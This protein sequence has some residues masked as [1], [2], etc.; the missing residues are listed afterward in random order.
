MLNND[1]VLCGAK[2]LLPFRRF[3]ARGKEVKLLAC[4]REQLFFILATNSVVI[5]PVNK[6]SVQILQLALSERVPFDLKGNILFPC[7]KT[8]PSFSNFSVDVFLFRGLG[9]FNQAEISEG[10]VWQST[11]EEIVERRAGE[12]Q[13]E[14]LLVF[15]CVIV[16]PSKLDVFVDN[17]LA[18]FLVIAEK[19]NSVSIGLIPWQQC[20]CSLFTCR[21]RFSRA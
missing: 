20:K 8:G 15:R 2:N 7:T 19:R 10:W 3:L 17:I 21:R 5:R 11:F 13:F 6:A 16:L 12:L 14:G 18:S 1:H 9:D 4:T